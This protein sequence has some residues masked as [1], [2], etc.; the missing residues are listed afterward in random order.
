M[1]WETK[2]MNMYL[3]EKEY[4]DTAIIPL[5]PISTQ[6]DVKSTVSMGEFIELLTFELERQFKGRMV[7]FPSFTYIT[8]ESDAELTTRLNEWSREF[9]ES[10]MKHIFFL[11]SHSEWKNR[12]AS[13][14][15]TL[16]W[17]PTVPLGNMEERLKKEVVQD[18]IKQLTPLFAK[19][20]SEGDTAS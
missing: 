12:E 18:Q 9:T 17:I 20:W 3:Q 14:E 6:T 13:L 4:V 8:S 1:K 7:L 16:M 19:K 5:V 11:T 10:G 2:D 15:G